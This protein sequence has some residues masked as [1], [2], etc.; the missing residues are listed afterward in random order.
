MTAGRD[1]RER[2]ETPTERLDR[3]WAEL[4]QELRVVQ[5]GVQFLTGSCSR[6]RS[7]NGS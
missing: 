3:N 7:S 4:L 6:F 1:E 5:T 2:N